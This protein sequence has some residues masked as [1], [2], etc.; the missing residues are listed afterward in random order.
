MNCDE[1]NYVCIIDTCWEHMSISECFV[2]ITLLFCCRLTSW[3]RTIWHGWMRRRREGR[4]R[5]RSSPRRVTWRC[6]R[7]SW[8]STAWSSTLWRHPTLSRL[9]TAL[10]TIFFNSGPQQILMNEFLLHVH[11]LLSGHNWSWGLSLLLGHWCK[12][13][14]GWYVFEN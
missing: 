11:I 14:L 8:K 7:G 2:F 9:G 3:W 4:T 12:D 5:G 10:C 13:G 1:N 6:T